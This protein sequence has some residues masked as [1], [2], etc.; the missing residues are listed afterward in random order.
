M[1]KTLVIPPNKGQTGS[2]PAYDPAEIYL[3]DAQVEQRWGAASGYMSE[4]RA[5][6]LGPPH[7]RL[8][9]RIIRYRASDIVAYEQ[10]QTFTSNAAVLEAAKLESSPIETGA[11]ETSAEPVLHRGARKS[12][13]RGRPERKKI[14][15]S[16]ELGAV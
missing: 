2:P 3:S 6:G 15:K 13:N 9:P 16:Q 5:Q 7:V 11:S 1:L 8:S 4:L 12:R 14:P 10:A